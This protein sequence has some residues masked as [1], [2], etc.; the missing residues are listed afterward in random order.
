MTGC[1]FVWKGLRHY[2]RSYLGVFLGS[3]L[4]ATVL[5]GGLFAGDSVKATLRRLAEDRIGRVDYVFTGGDVSNSS[6]R[7]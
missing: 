6:A 1:K 2:R 4:G 5:L 7:A 3:V